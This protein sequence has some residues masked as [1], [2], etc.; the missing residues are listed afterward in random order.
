MGTVLN[1]PDLFPI[2]RLGSLYYL[3]QLKDVHGVAEQVR[4][5]NRTGSFIDRFR[6]PLQIHVVVGK[7]QV[8]ETGRV[9]AEHSRMSYYRAGVGRLDDLC[10]LD[11]QGFEERPQGAP[12]VWKSNCKL[13]P[14]GPGKLSLETRYRI[15]A[16]AK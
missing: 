10:S 1:H 15:A 6:D 11:V 16:I 8:Y 13:S 3:L 7:L 5:N 2:A 12:P 14:Q 4:R 9:L